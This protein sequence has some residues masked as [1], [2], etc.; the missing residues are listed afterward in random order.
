MTLHPK[1]LI[2]R[3]RFACKGF[4]ATRKLGGT[5]TRVFLIGSGQCRLPSTHHTS[6]PLLCVLSTLLRIEGNTTRSHQRFLTP[7]LSR[8]QM[9]TPRSKKDLLFWLRRKGAETRRKPKHKAMLKMLEHR[10][11]RSEG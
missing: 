1:K 3:E 2:A 4:A 7:I 9:I 6:I 11:Q 8:H 10:S 5:S